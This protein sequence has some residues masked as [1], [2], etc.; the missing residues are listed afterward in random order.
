MIGP[1]LYEANWLEL[2]RLGFIAR[3]QCAEVWCPMSPEF[4]SQYAFNGKL[5][6]RTKKRLCWLNPNKFRMVNY[7][8]TFH[9]RRK[10]KIIVFCDDELTI[11]HYAVA[12][13]KP[14][15]R[16]DTSQNETRHILLNFRENPNLKTLF[17]GNVTDRVELPDA[18]VFIQISLRRFFQ[19]VAR[20]LGRI[21]TLV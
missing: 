14:F 17:V 13:G 16:G 3:V 7:L 21:V 2:Q 20:R 15:L 10:E 8:I 9:E 11:K 1:K 6:T 12:L 18:N 19:Q 5:S 4:Y